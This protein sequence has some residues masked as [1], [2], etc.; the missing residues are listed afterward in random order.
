MPRMW[1]PPEQNPLGLRA[2]KVCIAAGGALDPVARVA[3]SFLAGGTLCAPPGLLVKGE[4]DEDGAAFAVALLR[5]S[6]DE[7]VVMLPVLR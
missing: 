2:V 7:R 1:S 4:V 6:Q 5:P 3:R